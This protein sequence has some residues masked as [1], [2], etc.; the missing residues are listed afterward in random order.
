MKLN[1]TRIANV[2]TA[3]LLLGVLFLAAAF[4]LFFIILNAGST[5]SR[6]EITS[7]LLITDIEEQ[8]G[9]YRNVARRI[10]IRVQR[11]DLLSPRKSAERNNLLDLAGSTLPQVLK[12]RL[13]PLGSKKTDSEKPEFSYACRDLVA[14]SERGEPVPAAE[15]HLA[16]SASAH[17]DLLEP[18]MDNGRMTGHVVLSISPAT[19]QRSFA[20]LE[21]GI[22]KG[23]AELRQGTSDGKF[24]VIAKG[25]ESTLL[26]GAAPFSL[27]VP[28]THWT[29]VLWPGIHLTSPSTRE[30]L[31]F[32][33]TLVIGLLLL[34]L[35]QIQPNRSLRAAILHDSKVM[36]TLVNDIRNGMLMEHYPFRLKE[37]NSLA[38]YVR[39]SGESMIE[40][41]KNLV[42]RTQ[43]DSLTGLS[44]RPAFDSRL[45]YLFQQ[46]RA[47]FNSVLLITD[48][49]NLT[50]LSIQ[51]GP[52]T[53]DRLVQQFGRDLRAALRQSDF[54]AR[55]EGGRFAV[56]FPLADL[57]ST[58]PVVQRLRSLIPGQFDPGTGLPQPFQWSA[59]LTLIAASDQ[60]ADDAMIRAEIGLKAAQQEGGGR[61]VT[62]M[63]PK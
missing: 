21:Y 18:I 48:V 53:G 8:I 29:V 13:V 37:F 22:G 20:A 42:E 41:R 38:R 50:D 52:E 39:M 51:H 27:A 24:L 46:A 14:R 40:D 3:L 12:T 45:E 49:D 1:I 26:R 15:M 19:L 60:K 56:L 10:A 55:F 23:Y 2:G 17:I 61:T 47:G 5:Q 16:E 4:Y 28:N 58:A 54:V 9:Y 34:A 63:P 11:D 36:V 30:T 44:A 57:E 31:A 43:T 35:S 6:G 32:G 7:R 59:G 25:G 62:Q 33:A